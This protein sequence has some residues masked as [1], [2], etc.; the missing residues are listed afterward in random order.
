MHTQYK[1]QRN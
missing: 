1:K